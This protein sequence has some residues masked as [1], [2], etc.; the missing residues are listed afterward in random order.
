MASNSSVHKATLPI[1]RRG[2][3]KIRVRD[4]PRQLDVRRRFR[5]VIKSR[6]NGEGQRA[7]AQVMTILRASPKDSLATTQ[8]Y[9]DD[10]TE[11]P[12]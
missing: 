8:I 2:A 5:A 4:V 1:C 11:V 9:T 6:A 3:P 10:P 7:Q 12:P